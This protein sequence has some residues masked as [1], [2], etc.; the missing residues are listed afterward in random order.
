MQH[1]QTHCEYLRQGEADNFSVFRWSRRVP[2]RLDVELYNN[3]R[4]LAHPLEVGLVGTFK[5]RDLDKRGM[6]LETG[7][8]SFHPNDVI[9][10]RVAILLMG[11]VKKYWLRGIIARRTEAGIGILYTNTQSTE[12]FRDLAALIDIKPNQTRAENNLF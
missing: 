5:T 1:L 6:F 9:H 10:I 11:K 7:P 3:N 12:F 8:T 4:K 2:A